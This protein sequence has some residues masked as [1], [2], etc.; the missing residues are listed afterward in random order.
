MLV[1]VITVADHFQNDVEV[2]LHFQRASNGRVDAVASDGL[3]TGGVKR[4]YWISGIGRPAEK[5]THHS[6]PAIQFDDHF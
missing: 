1:E 4:R 2:K 5:R 3:D 6:L